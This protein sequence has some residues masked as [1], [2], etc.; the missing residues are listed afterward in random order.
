MDPLDF[1]SWNLG[2]LKNS[3]LPAGPRA[4]KVGTVA[5]TPATPIRHNREMP[6]SLV[7]RLVAE[8][9]LKAWLAA[10]AHADLKGHTLW[11]GC[12]CTNP[13]CTSLCAFLHWETNFFCT[14]PICSPLY[15]L[16][17]VN[18]WS[19]EEGVPPG[20]GGASLIVRIRHVS[21]WA[22]LLTR[23]HLSSSCQEFSL[24]ISW[25]TLSLRLDRMVAE[26]RVV[27]LWADGTPRKHRVK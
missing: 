17:I 4:G 8:M 21:K 26:L 16:S 10:S 2:S 25:V 23:L 7:W 13:H 20:L 15:R 3:E 18:C 19:M 5:R 22:N 1:L 27:N 14:C 11:D 9:G 24:P 6:W 12:F